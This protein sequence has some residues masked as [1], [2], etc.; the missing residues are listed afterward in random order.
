MIKLFSD[1][2]REA[3]GA[4]PS[5]K[6]LIFSKILF[7]SSFSITDFESSVCELPWNDSFLI[8]L[9]CKLFLV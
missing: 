2:E 9:F 1:W 6:D 7:G 4:D 8:F 3:F 5:F